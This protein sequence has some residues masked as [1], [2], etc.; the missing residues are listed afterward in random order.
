[1]NTKKKAK[2]TY[3]DDNPIEAVRD[4]G[5]A[6]QLKPASSDFFDQLFG[7]NTYK[8]EALSAGEKQAGE[9]SEGEEFDL[10]AFEQEQNK[11]DIEPGI[12]YRREILHSEVASTKE[13]RELEG[14]IAEIISELRQLITAS[15]EL[16][17]Q[18]KEAAIE[19]RIEKPGK[20]HLN[21]FEWMLIV[22]KTARMRVEDSASWLSMFA[23]KKKQ[24]QYWNQFKKHGTTFGLSNERVVA[25]QTG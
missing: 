13:T 4:Y 25:T 19:Q 14:Q 21:F 23:S 9:L 10:S 11:I 20:Y 22:I 8:T 7:R 18:F 1:M 3:F 15:S 6:D 12:D 5:F 2:K 16:Q 17:T 24:K